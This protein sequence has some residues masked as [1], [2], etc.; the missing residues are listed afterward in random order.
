MSDGDRYVLV[1]SNG[2]HGKE[3][4]WVGNLEAMPLTTI[5]LGERTINVK[6]TVLREGAER[7]RLYA[8]FTEFWPD[9]RKYEERSDRA[10][11]VIVLEPIA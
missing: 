2:G 3:P 1:G 4:L 10:F 7:D 9:L 5:E 11:P 8:E 6:P